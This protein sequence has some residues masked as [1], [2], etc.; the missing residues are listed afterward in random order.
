M[1]AAMSK[2]HED[3]VDIDNRLVSLLLAAQFPRWAD[4]PLRSVEPPGT[5]NVIYRLGGTMSVRLPRIHWAVQQPVKEHTWLP[6]LAAHLSLSI[7]E[8]L[9]LGQP[10][11]G[12]PW[13][14]SICTWLPGEPASSDRL[15]DPETTAMDLA[16]FVHELEAV[17][18]TEGPPP[19]GRGGPL[20]AR[21]EACRESIAKLDPAID[22]SW[23]EAEWDAALAAPVWSGAPV[24]IHGDLDARNL[25]ATGGRLSGV[26]DWGSLAVGDPAADVMVAWKMFDADVRERFRAEVHVDDA[27]WSRARGWVLSQAVMIL[28]YYTLETNAVLVM[29][30]ERWLSELL[31]DRV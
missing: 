11:E 22:R 27:T 13:H 9:A 15:D 24:W 1:G 31:A 21:D 18:G 16:R 10:G 25:L 4:L 6:R 3:E 7:P 17:D 20:H 8:P 5:D 2:M 28:S 12:Y 26:L 23:V 30:A 14:W 29:E 19:G